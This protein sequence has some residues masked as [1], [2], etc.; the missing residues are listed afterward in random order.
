[1]GVCFECQM[2][3]NGVPNVRTCTVEA[4]EGCKVEPQKDGQIESSEVKS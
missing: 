4:T 1:M 3:V 2:E